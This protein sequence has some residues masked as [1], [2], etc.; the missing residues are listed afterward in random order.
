MDFLHQ[1][2][3][4]M[5][6]LPI[7]Q[8][9]P[10]KT[11]INIWSY[12]WSDLWKTAKHQH[13]RWQITPVCQIT[14]Y[15]YSPKI[16]IILK[17]D[18]KG[19]VIINTFYQN[20]SDCDPTEQRQIWNVNQVWE[21]LQMPIMRLLFTLQNTGLTWPSHYSNVVCSIVDFEAVHSLPP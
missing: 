7:Y 19:S 12:M 15:E 3:T 1:K 6:C 9:N 18:T 17:P 10:Y 8:R 21:Q 20:V 16:T 13:T 11:K 4:D 14:G 5:L 2:Y